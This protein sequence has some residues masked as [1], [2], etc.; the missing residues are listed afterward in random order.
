MV[1]VFFHAFSR[2]LGV[3]WYSQS[4][5]GR[6]GNSPHIVQPEKSTKKTTKKHML[7]GSW[8]HRQAFVPSKNRKSCCHPSDLSPLHSARALESLP[9]YLAPT[10]RCGDSPLWPPPRHLPGRRPRPFRRNGGSCVVLNS[11][12]AKNLRQQFFDVFCS[13]TRLSQ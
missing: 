4:S 3:R 8:D 13:L 9:R 11:N 1:L 10:P 12:L 7:L 5:R 6:V 2:Y